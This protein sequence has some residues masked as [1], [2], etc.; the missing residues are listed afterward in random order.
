[1]CLNLELIWIKAF[2]K[3]SDFDDYML[4]DLSGTMLTFDPLLWPI[5][6]KI[7]WDVFSPFTHWAYQQHYFLK[8]SKCTY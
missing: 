5:S 7:Q 8:I 2:K 6:L 4:C 3:N 1:M